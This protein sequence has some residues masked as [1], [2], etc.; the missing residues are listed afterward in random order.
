MA[1]MLGRLGHRAEAAVHGK[2]GLERIDAA[3][4]L[5]SGSVPVDIVF[6]DK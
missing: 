2:D 6:L 4:H 1:R 5:L 3:Y